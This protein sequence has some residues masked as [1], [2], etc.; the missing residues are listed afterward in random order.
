MR[1]AWSLVVLVACGR[2]TTEQ[3]ARPFETKM[4]RPAQTGSAQGS[5]LGSAGGR[6]SDSLTPQPFHEQAESAA[7]P[8]EATVIEYRATW[9]NVNSQTPGCWFFSGPHG[10]D[11]PL[12][13]DVTVRVER[14]HAWVTWGKA[15]FEGTWS[16]ATVDV[17]RLATHS[18]LGTWVISERLVGRPK[19]K[20]I[21]ATYKYEECEE[22]MKCPGQ[23]FITADVLLAP[24]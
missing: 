13:E 3:G 8:A 22:G 24:K 12:G 5:A 23:C 6:D 15:T 21:H 4:P 9:A 2:E 7:K 10:R 16:D 1:G 17:M 20:G 18:Y 11:T 14:G 19:E